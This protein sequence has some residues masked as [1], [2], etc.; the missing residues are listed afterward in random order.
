M[1]K[2]TNSITKYK[3]SII[4]LFILITAACG[5]LTGLVTVNYDLKDY[6]PKDAKSTQALNIMTEE[7]SDDLPNARV[8]IDNLTVRE[9]LDYKE[10]LAAVDGVSSVTWLEDAVGIETLGSVPLEYL[11]QNIVKNYYL[12]GSAL[13][14]VAIEN[15]K[16]ESTVKALRALI[17]DS[18]LQYAISGDAVNTAS[19]QAMS[20]SEVLKAMAIL[21]PV[22]ISILIISTTSWLEPVLFLLSIGVAVVINMGTN[23]IFG[24]VSFISNAVSPILQ[25]AVSLDYAIFL[26]HS[27]ND[28]RQ[29][30]EPHEAMKRAIKKSASAISASAAT[31]IIGFAALAFMRFGIGFDM[32]FTLVKGV[33]LS[34]V[35]VM[36]FL[37]ALTLV[38]YKLMDKTKHR[39]FFFNLEGVGKV[40]MKINTPILILA[41]L[42]AVPCFL[43]QS[44][45]NFKYG[46][47][48]LSDVSVVAMDNRA[49]DEKFGSD[50]QLVLL[51]SKGDAGSEKE[52]CESLSNVPHVTSVVSYTTSVGSEIPPE[53]L[54]D[55]VS[56][57]FYSEH[58]ARIILYTDTTEEG[59]EAF[60]TVQTVADVAA[61]Y[62]DTYY[63]TGQSAVLYDIK[64]VVSTDT[65]IV[66]LIAIIGIFLVL[67]ITFRSLTIPLLLVFTIETAIW[68]NLSFAY[69]AGQSFNFIGY[70]VIST[71][72]LGATVDYAILMTDRYLHK[73]K[74]LPKKEAMKAA[75]GNKV[76]AVLTSAAI[77]ST[78]GFILAMTS[79]NPIVSELGT[80]LGRG[81][82]LSFFMVIC[83]LPE[84]LILFDK[85]I[86][87]TTLKLKE[88]RRD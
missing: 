78:A 55:D 3:K 28:L 77:L 45:V 80:L 63:L 30:Y 4:T 83:V 24:Q 13:F 27:F 11:D 88:K 72:Q 41:V 7:F 35:S 68:I 71:V 73:R 75:L 15:G 57:M 46:M 69:F 65:T 6:L 20:S 36:I 26:M 1:S 39:A 25:M 70:L 84:L 47:S 74:T 40:L 16:E 52:L 81:T 8:M 44:N 76:P 12:D 64:T 50:N 34:F 23:L 32:A 82:L 79:T 22:I 56:S 67:L 58:Y 53:Y 43:A 49:I 85:I 2:F 18:A 42:V 37:P 5:I 54:S 29:E 31:T 21:V 17:E 10:K 51:V 14:S 66:N 9:A 60:A 59:D 87:K 38:S 48:E 61:Q 86:Q 19:A 62:Y 33:I